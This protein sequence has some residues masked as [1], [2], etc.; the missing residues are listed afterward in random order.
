M[1]ELLNNLSFTLSMENEIM[2]AIMDGGEDPR[3][4]ARAWLQNNPSVLDEWLQGVTTVEGEPGLAAVKK[5]L[6]IDS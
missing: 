3:D 5:A 1:G 6:D 2:G 4:A